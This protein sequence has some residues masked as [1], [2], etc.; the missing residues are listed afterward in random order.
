MADEDSFLSRWSRRKVQDRR[1]SVPTD[2]ASAEPAAA[3]RSS[4]VIT[5]S[6]TAAATTARHQPPAGGAA[7]P[8]DDRI[9]PASGDADTGKSNDAAAARLPTLADVA[10]LT[11]DSDYSRFVVRGVD[12][13][14]KNAALKKL[15]TDPHFNVMD[16]LDTYIEDYGIPNPI[17]P[18]MLR[19]MTQSHFLG[20][21]DDEKDAEKPAPD[22]ACDAVDAPPSDDAAAAA[23]QPSLP[24]P[25]LQ[26]D[27]PIPHENPDL[28][29]QSN[30]VTGRIGADLRP[31]Q[32]AGRAH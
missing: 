11:R 29:L 25:T 18:S 4:P 7:S 9:K 22:I 21:F 31:G 30:D 26:L 23:T 15:F 6:S 1:S 2:P 27:C 12:G 24:D 17:S 28:R 13:E 20:L 14:V 32:H 16:G 3:A 10:E 5:S 8:Q 19:Q